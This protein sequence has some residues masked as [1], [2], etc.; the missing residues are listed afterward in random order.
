MPPSMGS[1]RHDRRLWALLNWCLVPE[2]WFVTSG[3]LWLLWWCWNQSRLDNMF[4]VWQAHMFEYIYILYIY[5]YFILYNIYIYI[6]CTHMFFNGDLPQFGIYHTPYVKE[7]AHACFLKMISMLIWLRWRAS[8]GTGRHSIPIK[9][10]TLMKNK[11]IIVEYT[12]I[13]YTYRS[14]YLPIHL[15]NRNIFTCPIHT[16]IHPCIHTYM[17]ACIHTDRHTDIYIYI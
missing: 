4:R 14:I 10:A 12:Y 3:C 6:Q 8:E 13:S 1:S 11:H 17:H 5:I 15:S 7:N 9:N 16:Y 2:R